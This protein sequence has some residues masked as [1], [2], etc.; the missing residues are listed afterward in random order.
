LVDDEGF[1]LNFLTSYLPKLIKANIIYIQAIEIF[2]PD[3]NHQ[4]TGNL[5][6]QSH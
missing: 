3:L 2:C 5:F 6:F 1:D 4:I